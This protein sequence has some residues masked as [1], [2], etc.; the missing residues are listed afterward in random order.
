[1]AA[2]G[3][4][5]RGASGMEPGPELRYLGHDSRHA[6]EAG[7]SP[8]GWR[9][10]KA[11]AASSRALQSHV[12]MPNRLGKLRVGLDGTAHLMAYASWSQIRLVCSRSRT[13]FLRIRQS[14]RSGSG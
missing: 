2:L 1:M 10:M 9:T 6:K 14:G 4:G 12:A 11:P 13:W 3:V 8:R 7:R 5:R